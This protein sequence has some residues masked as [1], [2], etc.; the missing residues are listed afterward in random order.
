MGNFI[1]WEN[2]KIMRHADHIVRQAQRTRT[3]PQHCANWRK[4]SQK[5]RV[6]DILYGQRS[7]IIYMCIS[8]FSTYTNTLLARSGKKNLDPKEARFDLEKVGL[9]FK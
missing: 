6:K 3:N 7:S 1:W 9:T 4:N 2:D 5:T 8:I